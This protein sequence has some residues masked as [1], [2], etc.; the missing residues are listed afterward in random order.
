[1]IK[2]GIY[3]GFALCVVSLISSESKLAKGL[4]LLGFFTLL[5][6]ITIWIH[7]AASHPASVPLRS[8]SLNGNVTLSTLFKKIA[9]LKLHYLFV[10]NLWVN[11][12]SLRRGQTL[13]ITVLATLLA[14]FF[15]FLIGRALVVGRSLTNLGSIDRQCSP[16]AYWLNLIILAALYVIVSILP[17]R[18]T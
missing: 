10:L 12:I 3:I 2:V 16:R 13:F 15:L 5:G 4:S 18:T 6:S 11:V 1:M 17:L 8:E 14:A 9:A 7:L